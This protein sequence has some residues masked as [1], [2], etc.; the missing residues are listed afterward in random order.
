MT[1]FDLNVIVRSSLLGVGAFIAS[2]ATCISGC[3]E[4]QKNHA[5]LVFLQEGKARGHCVITY[6]GKLGGEFREGF[7]FGAGAM[8]VS[9]DGDIDYSDSVR[10]VS[11]PFG[12]DAA[13]DEPVNP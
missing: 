9:F 13:V 6:D 4:P 7:Y 8:S 10:H 5:A 2:L 1:M 12:E 3:N 11:E